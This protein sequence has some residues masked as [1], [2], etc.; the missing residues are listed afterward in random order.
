MNGSDDVVTVLDEQDAWQFLAA[1]QL[2]RL[3][4]H[5]A[6]EVH[7]VPVNHL[8]SDRRIV[9]RTAEGSKLL[10][11]TMNPDVAYEVDEVTAEQATSVVARGVAVHLRGAEADAA[12]RLPLRSWLPT[13]KDEVVAVDVTEI[14]GRRFR[15]GA[16]QD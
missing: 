6:G 9:F 12:A 11:V 8:V 3:A 1:Q 15:L 14:S 4:F 7:V 13:D 5:L 16:T 10:G 2:G